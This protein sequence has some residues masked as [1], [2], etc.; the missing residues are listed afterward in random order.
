MSSVSDISPFEILG[1]APSA[2]IEVIRAAYRALAKKYHPDA[3]QGISSRE[4]NRRMTQ[5]NWAMDELERDLEGWRAKVDSMR[6]ERTEFEEVL[7]EEPQHREHTRSDRIAVRPQNLK[8]IAGRSSGKILSAT[9][10]GISAKEIRS[11]FR[12]GRI[13]VRRATS[14]SPAEAIFRITA[15]NDSTLQEATTET[16]EIVA[17]G[18]PP[19]KVDITI[20]PPSTGATTR[21]GLAADKGFLGFL[22]RTFVPG[23]PP[24]PSE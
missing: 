12:S 8:L 4:L 13:R 19:A 20:V 21:Q 2:E 9:A 11:R 23:A 10:P 15:T 5:I 6:R 17:P 24:P 16:I 14:P 22:Y 18:F 3:N 7:T 1:V